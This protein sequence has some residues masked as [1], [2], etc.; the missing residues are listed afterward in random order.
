[1]SLPEGTAQLLD[2]LD[3]QPPLVPDELTQYLMRKSGQDCKDPR[4]VRLTSLAAQRFIAEVIWDSLQL[5]KARLGSSNRKQLKAAGYKD[6]RVLTSEDLSKA[7]ADFG[8]THQRSPYI[9]DH[10]P[11]QQQQHRQAPSLPT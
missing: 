7:L 3:D 8:V 11:G 5:C 9:V 4:L 1:M 2:Q 10:Q 6:K